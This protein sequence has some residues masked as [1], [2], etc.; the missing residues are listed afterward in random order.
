MIIVRIKNL[1]KSRVFRLSLNRSFLYHAECCGVHL[2]A[3]LSAVQW[4]RPEAR[5]CRKVHHSH[6]HFLLV[7]FSTAAEKKHVFV[8]GGPTLAFLSGSGPQQSITSQP[9][10]ALPRPRRPSHKVAKFSLLPQPEIWPLLSQQQ[11]PAAPIRSRY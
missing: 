6:L 11:S 1:K 3:V 9:P 5:L 8:Y 2:K 7:F 10:A 4:C